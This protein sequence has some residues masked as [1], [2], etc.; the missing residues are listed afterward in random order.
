MNCELGTPGRPCTYGLHRV[1]TVRY[2]RED[3]TY[4]GASRRPLVFSG[5]LILNLEPVVSATTTAK[6]RR[7]F[8]AAW[9]RALVEQALVPGASVAKLARDHDVNTN[10]LFKWCR[11]HERACSG[12]RAKSAMVPVV[13][14]EPSVPSVRVPS[15]ALCVTVQMARGTLRLEGAIDAEVLRGLVQ[16]LSAR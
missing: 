8:D 9:K 16:A 15:E 14:H 5:R 12:A 3:R 11:Q 7:R 4:R 6:R 2:E 10:Q 13:I 1:D